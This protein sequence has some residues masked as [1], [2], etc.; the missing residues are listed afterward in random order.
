[1]ALGE[2]NANDETRECVVRDTDGMTEKQLQRRRKRN[3]SG[4]CEAQLYRAKD[5]GRLE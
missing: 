1:M 2:L 4:R 3:A 5:D